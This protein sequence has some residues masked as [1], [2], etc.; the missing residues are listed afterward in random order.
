MFMQV[1]SWPTIR[2][3]CCEADARLTAVVNDLPTSELSG[4]EVPGAKVLRQASVADR[5]AALTPA[6]VLGAVVEVVEQLHAIAATA[7]N[8]IPIRL[9]GTG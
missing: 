6:V 8:A 9:T 2:V 7:T 3:V 1:P 5:V 4:S